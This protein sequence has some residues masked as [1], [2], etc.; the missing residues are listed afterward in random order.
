[1]RVVIFSLFTLYA[2]PAVADTTLFVGAGSRSGGSVERQAGSGAIVPNSQSN[3]QSVSLGSGTSVDISADMAIAPNSAY[4][5]WL[6]QSS[7]SLQPLSGGT[8][9]VSHAQIGG[10]NIYPD[11]DSGLRPFLAGGIGASE[12]RVGNADAKLYPS[13]SLAGGLD[14]PLGRMLTARL[15]ARWTAVVVTAD[16]LVYCADGCSARINAGL[17]SQWGGGASLGVRF[18]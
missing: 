13:F 4:Q 7:H 6:S 9:R 8:L 18:Y 16:Y 14:I 2:L 1:M 17:W 10:I 3:N 11:P 5:L 12:I 15:E